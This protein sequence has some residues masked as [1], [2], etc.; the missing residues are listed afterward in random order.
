MQG[1]SR[2]ERMLSHL[3]PDV[4]I[5]ADFASTY[6]P[7]QVVND[8]GQLA[9]RTRKKAQKEARRAARRAHPAD[10]HTLMRGPYLVAV[11]RAS[12]LQAE[13]MRTARLYILRSAGLRG[14][15]SSV[16]SGLSE[17]MPER[18]TTEAHATTAL[19]LVRNCRIRAGHA[20]V[21]RATQVR[22]AAIWAALSVTR[23]ASEL[24]Y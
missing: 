8:T 19:R 14:C 20:V 7:G 10:I 17:H 13:R 16:S 1:D 23:R 18:S 24:N 9:N 6:V 5:T 11:T 12:A 3:T 21:R 2:R 15:S 22:I 4:Q